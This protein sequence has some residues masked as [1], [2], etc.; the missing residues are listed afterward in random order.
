MYKHSTAKE[1]AKLQGTIEIVATTPSPLLQ[2]RFDIP[3]TMSSVYCCT[4][5]LWPK[6]DPL[7][8]E[9]LEGYGSPAHN[10]FSIN[11]GWLHFGSGHLARFLF[12]FLIAKFLFS[13]LGQSVGPVSL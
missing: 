6:G 8:T 7:V 4:P 2:R 13:S 12:L 10:Q 1:Q 5:H 3:Q 11:I 9:G